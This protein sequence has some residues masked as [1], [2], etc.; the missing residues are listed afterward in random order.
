MLVLMLV[1]VLVLVLVPMLMLMPTILRVIV[2]DSDARRRV[3][4]ATM[5]VVGKL[6]KKAAKQQWLAAHS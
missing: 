1:L 6:I 5:P 3:N 2:H 4:S